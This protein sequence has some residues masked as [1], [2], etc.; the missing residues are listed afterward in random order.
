MKELGIEVFKSIRGL[1]V[2]IIEFVM[3]Y[4]K[5]SK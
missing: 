2:L 3:K 5:G 1:L 4:R